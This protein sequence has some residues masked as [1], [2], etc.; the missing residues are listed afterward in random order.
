MKGNG[1]EKKYQDLEVIFKEGQLGE[2]IYF[3]VK[4]GVTISK[5]YRGIMTKIAELGEG[6]FFGEMSLFISE[7]RTATVMAR[8]RTIVAAYDKA[9]FI[10]AIN[11]DPDKAFNVIETLGKRLAVINE[12]MTKLNTKGLLPK[13][14]AVKL[15]RYTYSSI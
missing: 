4:G 13:D 8:G 12:E 5:N 9:A 3:I 14:E 7:P 2:E 11:D 6:E 15:S 1:I 10:T